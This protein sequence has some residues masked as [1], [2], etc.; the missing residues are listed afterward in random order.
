MK[1]LILLAGDE[2]RWPNLSTEEQ[3]EDLKAHKRFGDALRARTAGLAGEA[4]ADSVDATTMRHE[5]ERTVLTDGPY[6]ETVEQVGGFYLIDVPHL[7]DAIALCELL[8]HAYTIEIRPVI[9]IDLDD[10][11]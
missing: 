4:L 1:Y 2:R 3:Q 8:P 6:A 10:A 11:G 7:D 5:G 9:D